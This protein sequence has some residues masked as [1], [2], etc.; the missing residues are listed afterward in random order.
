MITSRKRPKGRKNYYNK[1]VPVDSWRS[2]N[3]SNNLL[4]ITVEKINSGRLVYTY[5]IEVEDRHEFVAQGMLISN[6]AIWAGLH[7]NH[8]DT[9]KF[10]ALKDWSPEVAAMKRKDFNFAAP[11]DMT[12]VSTILDDLFFTA[13]YDKTHELHK[14]A[15]DVFWAA[16][17]HMCETG[18]PGFSIDVGPNAGEHLRNA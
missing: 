11:M 5:D 10:I 1:A 9:F 17:R 12:N 15:Y 18:E 4:P 16:T 14:T 3:A 7:W 8:K 13:Y 2:H 6:S